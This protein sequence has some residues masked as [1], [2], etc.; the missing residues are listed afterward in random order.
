VIT[1]FYWKILQKVGNNTYSSYRETA[2]STQ[3]K[4][5]FIMSNLTKEK[6]DRGNRMYHGK[7]NDTTREAFRA[8]VRLH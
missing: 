6:R 5:S 3:N 2:K 4:D 8:S 7:Y 1:N